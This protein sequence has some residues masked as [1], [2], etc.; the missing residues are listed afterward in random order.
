MLNTLTPSRAAAVGERV[1]DVADLS[2]SFAT[3]DGP[4]QALS[5][6]DLAVERGE[7]VSFIG[8]LG[9]RQDHAAARDRRSRGAERQASSGSTA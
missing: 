3:A 1:I 5:G 8:P 2:L 6:I 7:F 9:L 4:V